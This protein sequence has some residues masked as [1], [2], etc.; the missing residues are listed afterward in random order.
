MDRLKVLGIIPARGGSRGVPGKNVVEINGR[1]LID[2]SIQQG[3]ASQEI[4]TL[5]VS[6]DDERIAEICLNAGAEVPFIRPPNLATDDSPTIDTVLHALQFYKEKGVEYDAVCL[7]QPTSPLRP[8]EA[9]D[10]AINKFKLNA[11]D[12]LVSVVEVPHHY[13]PHWTFF[14]NSDD[15]L[16][17]S[18]GEATIISRRQDLSPAYIRNGCIYIT[19]ASVIE[20]DHSLYGDRI[21][22]FQMDDRSKLNIDSPE[23]LITAAHLLKNLL[24]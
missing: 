18:T 1:P 21:G 10:E 17:L 22:Y 4:D 14:S 15:T 5:I 12:S 7:L 20:N 19:R 8:P 6:T 24:V 9:I 16:S 11:W 23:D 13:N 2:Y 3:L